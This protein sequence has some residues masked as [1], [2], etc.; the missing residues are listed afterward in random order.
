[1]NEELKEAK[2]KARGW[3]GEIKPEGMASPRATQDHCSQVTGLPAGMEWAAE[4]D[5]AFPQ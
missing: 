2:R 5:V 1:M 4:R 3:E